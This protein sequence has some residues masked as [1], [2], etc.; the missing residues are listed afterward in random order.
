MKKLLLLAAF[1]IGATQYTKAQTVSNPNEEF[2]KNMNAIMGHFELPIN[3]R[4]RVNVN[5]GLKPKS[6]SAEAT[7]SLHT[8]T[9]M[10]FTANVTDASGKV[11]K[12]WKPEQEAYIYDVKWDLSKLKPGEYYVNIF[13]NGSS[14]RAFQFAFT[15]Q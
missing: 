14:E 6:P 10:P 11:V 13:Y 12:S 2:I 8:P 9:P 7:F 5:Y 3:E 15:K 1:S 4:E